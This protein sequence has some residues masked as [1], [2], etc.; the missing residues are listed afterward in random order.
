MHLQETTAMCCLPFFTHMG[1]IY[2]SFGT[3]FKKFGP[4]EVHGGSAW[5]SGIKGFFYVIFSFIFYFLS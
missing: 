2:V 4:N 3:K 5:G 1:M